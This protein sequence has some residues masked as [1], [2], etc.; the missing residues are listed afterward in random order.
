MAV[1]SQTVF[2]KTNLDCLG[3]SLNT[4]APIFGPMPMNMGA[5]TSVRYK[6][7]RIHLENFWNQNQNFRNAANTCVN[8]HQGCDNEQ[9]SVGKL[10][11]VCW[12]KRIRNSSE[13]R[14]VFVSFVPS[15][16]LA[17]FS[18]FVQLFHNWISTL[19]Y[20]STRVGGRREGLC[21][22]TNQ[23]EFPG[24]E[25]LSLPPTTGPETH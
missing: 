14:A 8:W 25:L 18:A 16:L 7:L 5:P 15:H 2:E 19:S 23:C 22:K 4:L 3:V 10:S 6:R 21:V 20:R 13:H 9:M 24:W 1:L 17:F 12:H 11:G